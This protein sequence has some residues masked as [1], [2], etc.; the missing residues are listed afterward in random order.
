MPTSVVSLN[1][2]GK[3][4]ATDVSMY[5]ESKKRAVLT[6]GQAVKQGVKISDRPMTRGFTDLVVTRLFTHGAT[7][8]FPKHL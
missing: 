2:N 4:T 8:N 7:K 5:L 6:K 1:T 3:G